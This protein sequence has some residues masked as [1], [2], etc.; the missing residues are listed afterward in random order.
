MGDVYSKL[1]LNKNYIV[2]KQGGNEPSAN[3]G[4]NTQEVNIKTRRW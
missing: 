2:E 4:W 3:T 1:V